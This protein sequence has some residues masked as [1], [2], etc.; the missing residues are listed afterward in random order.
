MTLFMDIHEKVE[1]LTAEAVGNAH[2]A[3]LE[4]QGAYGVD[5]KQYWFDEGSGQGVLPRRGARRRDREP[6]APR[7]A[8]PGRRP[9]RAG[10]GRPL[11]VADAAAL[12]P[13]RSA[14]HTHLP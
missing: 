9:A 5:Y 10:A 12:P 1:G 14:D 13:A 3:D 4:T 11:T 8:R 2:K 6:G 7:G